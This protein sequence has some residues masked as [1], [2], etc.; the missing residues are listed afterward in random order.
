MML[1]E[2]TRNRNHG[3]GKWPT[4]I[5]DINDIHLSIMDIILSMAIIYK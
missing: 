3:D 4:E 1:S 5:D 2:Q